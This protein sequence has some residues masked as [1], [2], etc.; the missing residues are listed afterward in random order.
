MMLLFDRNKGVFIMQKNCFVIMGFGQKK[1]P[2]TNRTIDLD[3]TYKK[4]IRPAV[5]A[6]GCK[7]IRADEI[8]DSGLIDK[9]MYALLYQADVVVADI[10][11]YN[12]NAI[13]ELGVRHS[14]RPYSTIIIKEGEIKIP[15]DIARNRTISYKHLGNEIS[16]QEAK[17]CVPR[18]K[19]MIENVISNPQPDSPLYTYLPNTIQPTIPE[20]EIKAIM[21]GLKESEDSIYALTEKAKQAMSEKKFELAEKIWEKLS[22]KVQNEKYYIQQQ[23]L[24]RYKSER[25]SK[26]SAL[27]DALCIMK[28]IEKHTD[29]ETLGIVGAINKRLWKITN[30]VNYLRSAI[31]SYKKGWTLYKDYYTGENYA[32][33]MYMQSKI[34]KDELQIHSKIEAFNTFEEIISIVQESLKMA[35]PEEIK[36]KYATLANSYY[37]LER[38]EDAGKYEKLFR[39]QNPDL[40]EIETFEKTKELYQKK[41]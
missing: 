33:C 22:K 41:S 6:A 17:E 37:A 23:A 35:E 24:C 36:W 38:Q 1:D 15:F 2:E 18:L 25:P 31:E 10:S 16:D 20:D 5:E 7:C 27:I 21:D 28:P 34:L 14:L 11:T 32:N 40:W 9:S 19:K 3:E 13:Y 26:L 8:I 29:T 12:P 4:I 39:N 30:D